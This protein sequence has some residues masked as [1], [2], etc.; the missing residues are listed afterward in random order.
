MSSSVRQLHLGDVPVM[1]YAHLLRHATA[2]AISVGSLRLAQGVREVVLRDHPALAAAPLA[3]AKLALKLSSAFTESHTLQGHGLVC[4]V[5]LVDARS[6]VKL[7]AC[8]DRRASG[9][10][11]LLLVSHL[12]EVVALACVAA[13]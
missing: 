2:V 12:L 8:H 5:R 11:Q 3:D 10:E 1:L 9:T 7:A 13:L 4:Q 6:S